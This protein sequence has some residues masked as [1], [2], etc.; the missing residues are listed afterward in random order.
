MSCTIFTV[1]AAYPA[2]KLMIDVICLINGSVTSPLIT[3]GLSWI[4]SNITLEEKN[5]CPLAV[6]LEHE[7][8]MLLFYHS[9]EDAT[10][11]GA[12]E[13]FGKRNL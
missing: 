9:R 8:D 2:P 12:E 4:T 5:V 3:F 13:T 10:A 1:P 6:I 7:H 11:A